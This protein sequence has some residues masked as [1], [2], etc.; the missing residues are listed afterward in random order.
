MTQLFLS[1]RWLIIT[2][3]ISVMSC[4]STPP[5]NF[6]TLA[7]ITALEQKTHDA[8]PSTDSAVAIGLGPVSF[9]LFLDRPQI[10]SRT[11]ANQLAVNELERW[12]G[13]LQDEFLR[14]WSENLAQL[15]GS[16]RIVILPSE[17]RYPLDVRL[18]AEILAFEGTPDGQAVLRVR[19]SLLEPNLEQVRVARESRYQRPVAAPG[20]TRALLTAL[21]W[22][23][24]DFSRE[25]AETLKHT[26]SVSADLPIYR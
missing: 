2:L 25:V 26:P 1:W 14:V 16:S 23:L 12:G 13:T 6:Y 15:T 4:A 17:L 8:P 5:A 9:P 11:S 18:S 21:S 10:V 24:A 19:W 22:T 7:P 3:C 20:D